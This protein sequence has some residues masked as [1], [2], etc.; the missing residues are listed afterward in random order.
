MDGDRRSGQDRREDRA[1]GRR[2]HDDPALL[3]RFD[4]LLVGISGQLNALIERESWSQEQTAD[5]ADIHRHTLTELLKVR[6][7]P[8]LSTLIRLA[9]AFDLDLQVSFIP[10]GAVGSS[11]PNPH[12]ASPS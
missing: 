12:G 4:A 3:A 5:A 8:Q 11:G 7:D 1:G 2:I 10:R 6:T 9:H